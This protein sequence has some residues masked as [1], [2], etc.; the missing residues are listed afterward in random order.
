MNVFFHALLY[1]IYSG[2]A[3]AGLVANDAFC[4]VAQADENPDDKA[5]RTLRRER[6]A[7]AAQEIGD[8]MANAT[9]M[10]LTGSYNNNII[11][12]YEA[13][14]KR[15]AEIEATSNVVALNGRA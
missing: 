3:L 10:S 11:A 5:L 15:K 1:Y 13:A 8:L 7:L 4:L 2:V 14:V 12:Q 6:V 9:T